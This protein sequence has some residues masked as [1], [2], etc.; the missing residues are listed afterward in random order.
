M[1]LINCPECGKEVSDKAPACPNC[2]YRIN[3]IDFS[4]LQDP[5]RPAAPAAPP[6]ASPAPTDAP[7]PAPK[8]CADWKTIAA[9]AV[10]AVALIAIAVVLIVQKRDRDYAEALHQARVDMLLSASD[11]A[12]V[13]DMIYSVWSNAIYEEYD[14]ATD[15]YTRPNG[16]WRDFNDALSSYFDSADYQFARDGLVKDLDSARIAV[17]DLKNPPKAY[18]EEYDVLRDMYS[19]Y[20]TFLRFATDPDGSLTT[21]SDGRNAAFHSFM[22]DY[23]ELKLL[24]PPEDFASDD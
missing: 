7:K 2:G 5:P 22:D 16:Y 13:S 19:S 23:D 20:S 6:P 1:A 4:A 18:A 3:P 21:Y 10:L 15:P 9:A 8:K 11:A 17:N 12:S 14:T 24:L